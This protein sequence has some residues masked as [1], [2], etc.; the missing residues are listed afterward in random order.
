MFVIIFRARIE[1]LENELANL[2]LEVNSREEDRC[3]EKSKAAETIEK[4]RKEIM[5]WQ[6][7]AEISESS[8]KDQETINRELQKLRLIALKIS[9]CRSR[10]IYYFECGTP[11]LFWLVI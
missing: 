2:R 3:N 7:R 1:E 8:L 6:E 5:T 10:F 11:K 9:W 4:L